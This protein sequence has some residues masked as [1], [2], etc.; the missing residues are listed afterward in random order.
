MLSLKHIGLNF[1][2]RWIFRD[3]NLQVKQGEILGIIGV[4]G[5]GKSSLLNIISGHLDPSEGEVFHEGE[6][7]IGPSM[8]LIPGYEDIQLVNQDFGLDVYHSV[9]ENVREK[10]LHLPLKQ[11]KS[12]I[13]EVL[14]LVGLTHLMTQKAHLL[15]GGEQQRLSIARALAW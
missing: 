2:G 9:E 13:D 3:V 11:Q 6:K 12:L 4:S 7:L 8:K 5:A 15:S 14:D 10:I 1:D